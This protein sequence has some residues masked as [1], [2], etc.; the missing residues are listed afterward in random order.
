MK[1]KIAFTPLT[2]IIAAIFAA[3]FF[4]P[5]LRAGGITGSIGFGATGTSLIG[6]DLATATS[7][8]L[9]DPFITTASGVYSGVPVLTPVTFDGFQLNPAVAPVTSLWS[10]DIGSI[11][12]SFNATSIVSFYDPVTDQLDIG[13]N[14]V[15]QV[16]GYSLTPG[17]WNINLSQS[18]TS[19]VF[20]S[21]AAVTAVPEGSTLALMISGFVG[22]FGLV[23]ITWSAIAPSVKHF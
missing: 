22:L 15:A 3:A 1:I 20:D 12:Y 6:G 7:F 2:A 21:S 8:T 5:A 16:T 4:S 19:L 14:G 13:G 11:D 17:T 18:G 10:F 23:R 9:S